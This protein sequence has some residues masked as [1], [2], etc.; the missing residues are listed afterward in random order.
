M[1][2]ESI[3]LSELVRRIGGRLPVAAADFTVTGLAALDRAGPGDISFLTNPKY[4]HMLA[5]TRAGAVLVAENA[6]VPATDTVLIRVADAYLVLA[7]LLQMFHPPVLPPE[8]IHPQ[9]VVDPTA[10]VG[11]N[12]RISPGTVIAAG[13]AI[14]ANTV[15]FPGVY[16][17][18]NTRVGCDGIIYSNVS[19]YHGVT[20]GDRVIIHSGAVVGSDGFGFARDGHRYE[21]IPQIGSVIIKDDVEIGANCTIDRG[22]MGMTVIETGVKL[23]NMI[24]L[25]HNV[26]VGEHTAIAAQTGVSGSVTIG[27]RTQ[28]AG[29]VGIGGHVVIGD[30]TILTA[31]AGIMKSIGDNM[32]ISGFPQMPHN[33]WRRTQ[34]ALRRG[35]EMRNN[36]KELKQE[37]ENLHDRIRRLEAERKELGSDCTDSDN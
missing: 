31:K 18:R 14:G 20:I 33:E 26:R 22:S 27:K 23:D 3:T 8:G 10:T 1:N 4:A 28:I 7:K 9:A 36:I 5:T 30:D 24:H 19:I 21:K 25:A 35:A 15:L 32:M 34:A 37:I 13:A 16:I 29:Q 11:E 12:V 2:A 6:E 17:G